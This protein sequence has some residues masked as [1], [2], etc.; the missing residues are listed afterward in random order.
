MSGKVFL[1]MQIHNT[2]LKINPTTKWTQAHQLWSQH[3]IKNPNH[4]ECISLSIDRQWMRVGE[5]QIINTQHSHPDFSSHLQAS[6]WVL[7]PSQLNLQL[8]FEYVAGIN[9]FSWGNQK[10]ST[11]QGSGHHPSH[12]HSYS[13]PLCLPVWLCWLLFQGHQER[14]HDRVEEE[15]QSHM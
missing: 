9:G 8:Q 12:W 2:C 3:I 5:T 11:C 14:A 6:I 7:F 4:F 10:R 15:V 1:W 13:R